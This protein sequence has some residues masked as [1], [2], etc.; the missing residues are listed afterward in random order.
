MPRLSHMSLVTNHANPGLTLGRDE[1]VHVIDGFPDSVERVSDGVEN[2]RSKTLSAP[3][4][5]DSA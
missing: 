1:R 2:F 4:N 5:D 3:K